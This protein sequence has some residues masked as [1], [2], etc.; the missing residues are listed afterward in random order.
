MQFANYRGNRP[1][2]T[3]THPATHTHTPTPPHTQTNRQDRLQ[4]TAPLSLARSVT[5]N[6]LTRYQKVQY[7]LVKLN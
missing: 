4:Y 2:N 7:S 5:K 1:T 3:P 6:N